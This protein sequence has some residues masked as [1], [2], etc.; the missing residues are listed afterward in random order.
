[1]YEKDVGCKKYCSFGEIS[2]CCHELGPFTL[3]C[4]HS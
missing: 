1:M 4:L 3:A 2:C